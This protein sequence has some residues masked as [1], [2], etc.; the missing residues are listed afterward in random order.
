[1]FQLCFPTVCL[2]PPLRP[3]QFTSPRPPPR[4][5]HPS[6]PFPSP[7]FPSALIPPRAFFLLFAIT[8]LSLHAT[9]RISHSPSIPLSDSI[10]NFLYFLVPLALLSIVLLVHLLILSLV[11]RAPPSFLNCTREF[12]KPFRFARMAYLL[13]TASVRRADLQEAIQIGVLQLGATVRRNRLARLPTFVACYD[14]WERDRN[15]VYNL[16]ADVEAWCTLDETV[17]LSIHAQLSK[18]IAHTSLITLREAHLAA[19]RSKDN[20]AAA[21]EDS[22]P[23]A[24]TSIQDIPPD[25]T[26]AEA[27]PAS[28]RDEA[29]PTKRGRNLSRLPP[30]SPPFFSFLCALRGR[31]RG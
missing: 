2:T 26:A 18:T 16:P 3:L 31:E 21:I 14:M 8:H 12:R 5:I 27:E 6:P 24:Q 4:F 10:L 13:S 23:A 30:L 19:E 7:T 20:A 15:L 9:I 1:M 22:R 17:A 11:T 25:S 29:K 28:A